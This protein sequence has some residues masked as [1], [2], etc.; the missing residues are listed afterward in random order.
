MSLFPGY[1]E[2]SSEGNTVCKLEDAAQQGHSNSG[3]LDNNAM[4]PNNF[5]L[6]T[7]R[8]IA[9]LGSCALDPSVVFCGARAVTVPCGVPVESESVT[10]GTALA[11]RDG[12]A[13]VC[14]VLENSAA[15]STDAPLALFTEAGSTTGGNFASVAARCVW[16]S[17]RAV[18]KSG[19]VET[20][21]T[22]EPALSA[23]LP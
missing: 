11:L 13:D 2:A 21:C 9:P 16:N 12:C 8:P 20:I 1:I 23:P 5:P 3:T 6:Q 17:W 10:A 14:A 18:S 19:V 22:N 4:A 15:D 7:S